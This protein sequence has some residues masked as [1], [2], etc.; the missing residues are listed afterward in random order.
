MVDRASLVH[1]KAHK[2]HFA[3]SAPNRFVP[4]FRD[5]IG[6]TP[7]AKG[8]AN[9][10]WQT[11]PSTKGGNWQFLRTT[12]CRRLRLGCRQNLLPL[13]WFR[14]GSLGTRPGGISTGYSLVSPGREISSRSYAG[15]A[16][17]DQVDRNL[18]LF[19]TLSLSQRSFALDRREISPPLEGTGGFWR[20][21]SA[22][23]E[24]PATNSAGLGS[25][26]H[27]GSVGRQSVGAKSLRRFKA[28]CRQGRG[29]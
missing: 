17:P 22:V 11:H 25:F 7:P 16:L 13:F 3:V 14:G 27:V 9:T 1:A 29:Q 28:F 2:F 21:L 12:S 6:V 4:Q 15:E 23:R 20:R 19:R 18:D 26:G 24:S 8:P 5:R 10:T